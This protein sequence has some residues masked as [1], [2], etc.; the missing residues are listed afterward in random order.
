MTTNI[1]NSGYFDYEYS[2]KEE[3]NPIFLEEEEEKKEKEEDQGT[4]PLSVSS[5]YF[6]YEYKEEPAAV[7]ISKEK[8]IEPY[9]KTATSGYFD[10]EYKQQQPSTDISFAREFAYGKAQEPL[11]VGSLFRLGKAAVQAAFDPDETYEE[12]RKRIEDSRQEEIFEEFSEFRGREE[13]AG[14]LAGRAGIALIDPVTFIVPWAKFAKLGKVASLTAGGSFAAADMALREEALYG[15]INPYVV[16]LGFGLGVAGA[17]VGDMVTAAYNRTLTKEVKE[18]VAVINK[19][20]NTTKKEVNIPAGK[21]TPVIKEKDISAVEKAGKQTVIDSEESLTNLGVLSTKLNKIKTRRSE[22]KAEL[23]SLKDKRKKVL[24][25]K[26]IEEDDFLSF[27]TTTADKERAAITKEV[28]DLNKQIKEIYVDEATDDLLDV[29]ENGMLNGFKAKILDEGMARALIHETVKPLLFGTVGGAIGA[30]FTEEGDDN[31]KM[32]YMAALGATLGKFQQKIQTT[33]FKAIPKKILN[34]AN[35]EF[36]TDIRRSYWNVLKDIS[37][38]SHAQALLSWMSPVVNYST[39][40][41]GTPI[42]GARLGK[43]VKQLGVEEEKLIQSGLWRERYYDL[44]SRHDDDMLILAGKIVNQRG[45]KSKKYSFLSKEDLANPKLAEA[46]VLAKEINEFTSDFKKY[47]EARGLDFTE[48]AQYG[49]TQILRQG[50]I[51]NEDY[52]KHV[53]ALSDAFYNQHRKEFGRPVGEE[54]INRTKK[55]SDY[56]AGEF[57][58]T[59]TNLRK[60]SIWKKEV[61]EPIFEGNSF[62]GK[63]EDRVNIPRAREEEFVLNAARHFNKERTLYDQESRAMVSHLFEQNPAVTLKQLIENT[64]QVAEFT[65]RFG[66]R[67]EGIKKLFKDIDKEV[68]T[69]VD[70]TGKYGKQWHRR[71]PAA[72]AFAQAQKKQIKDSLEAYFGVYHIDAMPTTEAGLAFTTFL[73]TGLATT[74]LTRVSLPSLGDYL[75]TISNSGYKAAWKGAIKD[76]KLSKEGLALGGRS[77]QV[78]GK[79]ATYMQRFFG[80]NLS[81]NIV[82][83][84]LSDVLLVG[85][86]NVKNYQ[87]KT[88]DFTRRYFEAI[89]LGR[90]TRVARNFAFDSGVYRAMDISDLIGKGKTSEFLKTESALLKEMNSL[91]LTKE[92][93]KYISQ[94]KTIEDAIADSTAKSYLK[95]AGLKSANRDALIPQV[96]NRRLFTQSKNPYVKFLGSFLSWAQAKTSQTNALVSRIEEG[97]AA[98]FLRIVGAIP[99]YM[100]VRE[101]QIALSPNEKYRELVAE[102]T[103]PQKIGEGVLYSGAGTWTVE[104]LRNIIKFDKFGSNVLEQIAPV[105]KYMEELTEIILRPISEM[106]DE[107]E[108]MDKFIVGLGTAAKETAQVVP[109][110]REFVPLFEKAVEGGGRDYVDPTKRIGK[111]DGGEIDTKQNPVPNVAPEPSERINPY[112]GEPYEAEMERLGFKDGLLVSIGVTPVS[113][114]QISKLTKSLKKR[115]AKANGGEAARNYRKEYDNYQSSEKQKKDRAHRNNANRQLKREGRILKGDGKD[116]DHKDGNPRNNSPSNLTVKSKH[117]NRTRKF[118]GGKLLKALAGRKERPAIEEIEVTALKRMLPQR[119][120]ESYN[121]AI[122]MFGEGDLDKQALREMAFVESKYANDEGTFRKDNRSAYQI[123]PIRFKEFQETMNPNNPRGKGLRAYTNNLKNKYNLDLS[124]LEYDD[125]NDPVVG[126]AVTRALL[127]LSPASIGETVDERA[128][129]WKDFWNTKEGAGTVQKYIDDVSAMK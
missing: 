125:L 70:P 9:T 58:L 57:L 112:T 88:L 46:G 80:D 78:K 44:V 81:E 99:I 104:K 83:R 59:S 66:P 52:N 8:E 60:N 96:G 65:K 103:I 102:E 89:Q 12:A 86:G 97:D 18:T 15:E 118:S 76:I 51:K 43:V 84:E 126:T 50:A 28:R 54:A 101:T 16:G 79:D 62:H 95:K 108:L 5:G 114:K 25:K 23:K 109:I 113:E 33:P 77:K 37:A 2:S 107:E 35:D 105:L 14:V 64:I 24:T 119:G 11:V 7:L 13:T 49:L 40:M 26:E 85:G 121:Y 69:L 55:R 75:Q 6:D 53:D 30:T 56:I 67:G 31:S 115:Q 82:E 21:T 71:I 123:T 32:I 68:Q 129:Q 72:R 38:G 124:K 117:T 98:L 87:R 42:A 45:L 74:R 94:F 4:N 17:Q 110:T 29:F 63:F 111:F 106:S 90:V 19:K 93:F 27:M 61:D 36:V 120:E 73:Q 34:A 10:Y 128:R 116:V 22:I 20:G 1:Q 92:K 122:N 3:D 39:K 47:A 41:F 127:K 91:G 100:A 48:E